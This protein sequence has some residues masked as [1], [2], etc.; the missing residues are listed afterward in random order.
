LYRHDWSHPI[1]PLIYQK[2]IIH[3]NL[4]FKAYSE[5]AK[6]PALHVIEKDGWILDKWGVI[7]HAR[8]IPVVDR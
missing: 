2:F 6:V 8:T 4:A 5:E 1:Y 3:E 7:N